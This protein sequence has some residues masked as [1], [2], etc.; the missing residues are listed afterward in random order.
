MPFGT[1]TYKF[2]QETQTGVDL[3]RVLGG[4]ELVFAFSGTVHPQGEVPAW[5]IVHSGQVAVQTSLGKKVLGT[6][7]PSCPTRITQGP[8]TGRFGFELKLHL[9]AAQL[10]ALEDHRNGERLEFGITFAG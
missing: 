3:R 9:N 1:W 5:I 8:N 7:R 4:H 6:A 2:V 10:T